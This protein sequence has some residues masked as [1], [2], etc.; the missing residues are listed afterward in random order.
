MDTWSGSCW[1]VAYSD[2]GHTLAEARATL[3]EVVKVVVEKGVVVL[4]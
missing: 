3:V 4:S 1:C 2:E